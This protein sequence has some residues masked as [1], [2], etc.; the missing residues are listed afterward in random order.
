MVAVDLFEQCAYN[1]LVVYSSGC[2]S[3]LEYMSNCVGP[4]VSG[5]TRDKDLLVATPV[6]HVKHAHIHHALYTSAVFLGCPTAAS[7]SPSLDKQHP[8]R[9]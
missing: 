4:L 9:V 7:C 3:L 1:E 8:P 5:R 2:G 6:H